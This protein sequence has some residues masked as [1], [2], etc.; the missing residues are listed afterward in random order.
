LFHQRHFLDMENVYQMDFNFDQPAELQDFLEKVKVSDISDLE[1]YRFIEELTDHFDEYKTR[2][3][4]HELKLYLG[5][6]G[7]H[8]EPIT[9]IPL[10]KKPKS[11]SKTNELSLLKRKMVEKERLRKAMYP[12]I[13]DDGG[14]L[15][16]K[17]IVENYTKDDRTPVAKFSN[18]YHF[19]KYEHLINCSQLEY[20]DFV[21][22]EYDVNMSKILPPTVKFHDNILPLLSRMLKHLAD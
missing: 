14:Y 1:I 20:I 22:M 21:I 2:E 15:F 10:C 12:Q 8:A 3:V 19:F 16:F 5:K 4:I 13:F 17:D 6:T 7:L 11:E 9:T 18:L